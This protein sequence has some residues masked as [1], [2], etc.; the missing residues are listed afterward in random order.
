[1]RTAIDLDEKLVKEVVGLTGEK[2]RGRAVNQ[3][4]LAFVRRQRLQRLHALAGHID[5]VDNLKELEELEIR[6]LSRARW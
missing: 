6:E 1:M 5:L 3:A 2:S 4:L